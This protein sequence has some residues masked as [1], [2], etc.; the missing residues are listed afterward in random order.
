[1]VELFENIFLR[2]IIMIWN[3]PNPNIPYTIMLH[4]E[5]RYEIWSNGI[6]CIESETKKAF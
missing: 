3:I 4:S 5:C 1:M 2:M 6:K